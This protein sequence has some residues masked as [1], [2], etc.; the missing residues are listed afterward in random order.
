MGLG[1]LD[2]GEIER[3]LDSVPAGCE[4][5]CFWPF[6]ARAGG[7]GVAPTTKGRLS[8]LQLSHK[9]AHVAR[10]VVE[11]LAFEL[12]RHLLFLERG[13]VAVEQLVLGGGTAASKV[14]T[15]IIA[16]VTGLPLACF[17]VGAGSVLGAAILARGL[18]E[19]GRSLAKLSEE[20]APAGRTVKPGQHA[21]FYA[22]RFGEYIEE[23]K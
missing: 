10:A 13:G 4:G 2:H 23:L 17:G 8:G 19:S 7:A 1:R 9:P 11:G 3:L 14:T 6:M 18:V 20:M 16:D 22:K 5:V 15:Q 12:K 21:A